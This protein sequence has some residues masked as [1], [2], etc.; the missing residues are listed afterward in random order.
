MA[1][2]TVAQKVGGAEMK[3]VPFGAIT[4]YAYADK[5]GCGLQQFMAG[6]RK[7]NLSTLS[8]SDL[9]AANR[10][11]AAE[12]GLPYLTEAEHDKAMAILKA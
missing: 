11:T 6:A 3:R 5:I 4:L 9:M 1:W 8:R 10:E 7:S 2:E 12:T